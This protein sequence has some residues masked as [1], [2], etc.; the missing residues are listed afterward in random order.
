M[1]QKMGRRKQIFGG[2]HGGFFRFVVRSTLIFLLIMIFWPGDNLIRWARAKVEI[3][4]QEAQI[5]EYRRQIREMDD[6]IRMLTSDLDTLE[7]FAREHF[8]LAAPGDDV[9]IIES[10]ADED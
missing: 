1:I 9:Y 6:H 2:E 3:A 5:Q 7:K 4:R 10:G 8:N